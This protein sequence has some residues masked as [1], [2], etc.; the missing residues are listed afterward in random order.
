MPHVYASLDWPAT[1]LE[2]DPRDWA[3]QQLAEPF[4]DDDYPRVGDL[5]RMI[6]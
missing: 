5:D 6:A 4:P 3:E 1:P 2:A